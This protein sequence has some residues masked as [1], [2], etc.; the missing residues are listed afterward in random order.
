MGGHGEVVT[1]PSEIRPALD[2]AEASGLPS[3][4]EVHIAETRRM[5]SN[6]A[7]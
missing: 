1:D 6:Y 4:V 2:R 5:S 7:Q 3:L